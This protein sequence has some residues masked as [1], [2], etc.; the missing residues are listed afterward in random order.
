[1]PRPQ[2]KLNVLKN[3]TIWSISKEEREHMN[4]RVKEIEARGNRKT[5][6]VIKK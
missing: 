6:R 5:V 4:K 2:R 3:D 1:M